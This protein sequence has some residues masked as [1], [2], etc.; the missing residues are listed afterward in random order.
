MY[1]LVDENYIMFENYAKI[2]YYQYI[3]MMKNQ[4]ISSHRCKKM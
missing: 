4:G 1:G 3:W 2:E